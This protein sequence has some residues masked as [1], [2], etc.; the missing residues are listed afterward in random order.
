MAL[1][2]MMDPDGGWQGVVDHDSEGAQG[3]MSRLDLERECLEL[4]TSF[5]EEQ[6]KRA[7]LEAEV[8]ELARIADLQEDLDRAEHFAEHDVSDEPR[9]DHGRWTAG[10]GGTGVTDKKTGTRK[11]PGAGEGG[12]APKA[13]AAA[14]RYRNLARRRRVIAAVK[15]E[16]E[17][18]EA[19]DGF[20]LPD[21]EPADV[22]YARDAEGRAVKTADHF[23]R[24]LDNRETAV[25]TLT[26][27]KA[28]PEAKEAAEK[29][30]SLPCHFMEV[31]TLLTSETG[32]AH[33]SAKALRRKERWRDRY[34]ADFHVVVVD[35]RK[36]HK[37]S[38]HRVHLAAGELAKTFN[39]A[40]M[41][42]VDDMA[43][44][45]RHLGV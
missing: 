38:G 32:A 44:I 16:G 12:G 10:G 34:G 3:E 5:P 35:D 8:V 30:L 1:G 26:S 37:H 17:L 28:S 9:D 2:W 33:V 20:N 23:R 7:R 4:L 24:F 39:V 15:R 21:S 45:A 6:D 27:G 36:G 13:I 11:K 42:K 31:K 18:A 22:V 40:R 29:V 19:V 43:S 41:Q 25:K 14:G